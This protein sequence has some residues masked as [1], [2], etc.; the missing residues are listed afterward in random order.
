MIVPL[1]SHVK[2]LALTPLPPHVK[3]EGGVRTHTLIEKSRE[4][5]SECLGGGGSSEIRHGIFSGLT[6]GLGIFWGFVGSPGN[7]FRKVYVP[8]WSEGYLLQKPGIIEIKQNP[9]IMLQ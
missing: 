3:L 9:K 4:H 5:S 8:E 1:N 2:P 6:F 7:F